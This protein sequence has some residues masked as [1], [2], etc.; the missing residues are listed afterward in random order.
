M[1]GK[2]GMDSIW[3]E[4][5]GETEIQVKTGNGGQATSPARYN[6]LPGDLISS[7]EFWAIIT[8]GLPPCTLSLTNKPPN[9]DSSLPVHGPAPLIL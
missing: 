9:L 6:S 7:R 1:Q 5:E 2:K 4:R 3:G 8:P